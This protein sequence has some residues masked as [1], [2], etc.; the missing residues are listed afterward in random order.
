MVAIADMPTRFNLFDLNNPGYQRSAASSAAIRPP[1]A[2]DRPVLD[3][4][5]VRGFCDEIR[6]AVLRQTRRSV[7]RSCLCLIFE[8]I[9]GSIFSAMFALGVLLW[10]LES[11]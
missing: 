10:N 11:G 9:L 6:H 5:I 4:H 8:T 2:S 1:P 3:T 7:F